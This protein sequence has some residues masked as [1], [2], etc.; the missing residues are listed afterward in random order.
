MKH[1]RDHKHRNILIL[2]GLKL[3]VPILRPNVPAISPLSFSLSNTFWKQRDLLQ[4]LFLQ[5]IQTRIKR[6]NKKWNNFTRWIYALLACCCFFKALECS[7]THPW[8]FQ[9]SI[10]QNL[11]K[12]PFIGLSVVAKI[13]LSINCLNHPNRL[14]CHNLNVV[15]L[16]PLNGS[17]QFSIQVISRLLC[18][19]IVDW[20]SS[21]DYCNR[22]QNLLCCFIAEQ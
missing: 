11:H 4:N 20:Y 7:S 19:S 22:L 8:T 3:S 5:T 17:F 12:T 16:Y 14:L 18:T 1:K 21:F 9:E 13:C 15:K 6:Y 10:S 2:Y